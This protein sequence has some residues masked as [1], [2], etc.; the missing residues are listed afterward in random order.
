MRN[1]L[2]NIFHIF[3]RFARRTRVW[4]GFSYIPVRLATDLVSCEDA[5]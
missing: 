4:P 1:F 5:V 2:K 3:P